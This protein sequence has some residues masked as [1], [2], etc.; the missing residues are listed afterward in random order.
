M[1]VIPFI[2]PLIGVGGAVY[3]AGEQK[4]AQKK[5]IAAGEAQTAAQLQAAREAEERAAMTPEEKAYQSMLMKRAE[6]GL[7][8]IQAPDITESYMPK[9]LESLQKYYMQRGWQPSPRETGLLIEPSQ[10]VARDVAL[11]NALLRQSAQEAA[12]NKALA[13]YPQQQRL[14]EQGAPLQ[15]LPTTAGAYTATTAAQQLAAQQDYDQALAMQKA[16][17]SLF[18]SYAS[19]LLQQR[20]AGGGGGGSS[21]IPEYQQMPS[22]TQI[23][24]QSGYGLS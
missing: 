20:T 12:W 8:D 5:G 10:Q 19:P 23:F 16:F 22:L 11:Q 13:V 21:I 14:T 1:P 15:T 18:M 2:A 3:A 6:A 17:G 7:T 9:A 4:K 24:Q